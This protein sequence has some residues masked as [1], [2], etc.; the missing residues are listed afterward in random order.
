MFISALD[1]FTIGIGPSSSH[2]LGP[3]NASRNFL[4]ICIHFL[5]TQEYETATIECTLTGSLA[6]TGKGHSTDKAI[7]LGLH[8]Y[9]AHTLIHQDVDNLITQLSTSHT[10]S[11]NI[12]FNPDIHIIFDYENIFKESPNGMI[13]RLKHGHSILIEQIYFSIGGGFIKTLEEYSNSQP[14]EDLSCKYPFNTAAEMLAMAK[15]HHCTIA[16]MKRRNEL[17]L[18]EESALL[19]G[20]DAIY[21]AMVSSIH[22]GL[23]ATGVLPGGLNVHRRANNIYTKVI[24]NNLGDNELLCA[25]AMAVNEENASG[26]GVVTAP[27]NG[28]AGVIPATLYFLVTQKHITR[29]HIHEYLLTAAAIGGIIKHNSSI[30][31]AEVGCQ[32]EVGSASAM[33]AAGICAVLGGTNEQ[34]EHAAEIALEHHIG[35]TCD[36]VQGLV[37]IPCIERNGFGAIKALSAANLSLLQDGNHKISLDACIEAMYET[38]LDMS[39][40]YKETSQGGLAVNFTAC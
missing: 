10:L 30:S 9:E 37:Q 38:G 39:S 2:T 36:P 23:K 21:D 27:T 1:L 20:L 13:F 11:H 7:I 25:Y 22:K 15:H 29:E 31:G 33:A 40:K 16:E 18:H 34:I 28:A 5:D 4:D 19:A 12:T 26:H 6:W 8:N 17:F 3:L 35:M 24:H 32:G 14:R